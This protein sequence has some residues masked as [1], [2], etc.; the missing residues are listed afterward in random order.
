MFFSLLNDE[1]TL[2]CKISV[3]SKKSIKTEEKHYNKC[4]VSIFPIPNYSG[5]FIMILKSYE[6]ENLLGLSIASWSQFFNEY[7]TI[8]NNGK[9]YPTIS[10]NIQ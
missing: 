5:G 6:P 3:L 1:N 8:S 4:S 7:L 2:K 9:Q 10:N